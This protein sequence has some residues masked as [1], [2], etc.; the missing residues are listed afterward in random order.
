[1]NLKKE[2]YRSKDMK[3]KDL[4]A[5]PQLQEILID[6]E[7]IVEE[8]GEALSFF[9]HDRIPLEQYTKLASLNTNDMGEMFMAMKDLILDEGGMPVMSD[10][11]V[12]PMK[13]MNAAVLKVTESLG[14]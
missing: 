6:D 3:L 9:V 11:N 14:K 4:A 5:K 2:I 13:V 1:M 8:Y 12:L 10:G 7:S